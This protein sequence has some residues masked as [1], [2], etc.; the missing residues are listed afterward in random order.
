MADNYEHYL[1]R[2][3]EKADHVKGFK[4]VSKGK[5]AYKIIYHGDIRPARLDILN[6]HDPHPARQE[7]AKEK[8]CDIF[9]E[10]IQVDYD[11]AHKIKISEWVEGDYYSDLFEKGKLELNMFEKLGEQMAQLNNITNEDGHYLHNDDI[12][13][14]NMLWDGEKA[15]VFDMDRLWW[16]ENPDNSYVKILLKRLVKREYI[17]AFIKGYSRFRD[18]SNIT[19]LCESRNWKWK[20]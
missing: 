8:G 18:V 3:K 19:Q 20:R 15:V 6:A 5:P 16:E 7:L 11:L 10:I 17:D 13:M 1:R 2:I 4:K 12:T 14:R 9:P